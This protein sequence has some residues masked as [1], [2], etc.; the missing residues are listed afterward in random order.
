[1]FAQVIV[2]F[3]WVTM[4]N[5]VQA[6]KS[7]STLVKRSMLASSSAASTSSSTQNGL[8]RLRKIANKS[9]TQVIVFSPPLRSEMLRGSLPGGRATISMPL[10]RMSTFSSK[11]DVGLAAAEEIAEKRLEMAADGFQRLGEQP[12]AVGVDPLDDLL[13]RRL[14]RREI[15]VLVGERFVAGLELFELVE[16]FEVDVAEVVDLLPQL[17]DLLLHLLAPV[18][19]FV[20]RVGCSNSASFDAVILA[21]AVGQAAALVADLVGGQVGGVHLLFE[22]AKLGRGPSGSRPASAAALL[23]QRLAA[24]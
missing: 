5:C 12:P 7:W 8:G 4:M 6:R 24:G 16:G 10:S 20:A 3:E 9:A 18:L 23:L 22:L 14:G 2:F 17:F 11:I 21:E 19:L 1:M 15:V 13:Q